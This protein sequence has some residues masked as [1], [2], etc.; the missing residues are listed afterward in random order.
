MKTNSVFV[1]TQKII[2]KVESHLLNYQGKSKYVLWFLK[3]LY[4]PIKFLK[5]G[6]NE[7]F[8]QLLL[9]YIISLG[10]FIII[11][12]SIDNTS[13]YFNYK[14]A[15]ISLPFS[16]AIG[17]VIFAMP[18]TYSFS[19]VKN[20]NI[21]FI[22]NYLKE[23]EIDDIATIEFIEQNFKAVYLSVAKR[24]KALKWLIGA[25]WAV[26]LYFINFVIKDQPTDLIDFLNSDFSV[27][28]GII[29]FFAILMI[30]SYIKA[31]DLLFKSIEFSLIEFKNQLSDKNEKIIN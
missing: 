3:H 24:I 4:F 23:L 7:I 22:V 14:W 15:I 21:E 28:S 9:I 25:S 31:S 17:L 16:L 30:A 26:L 8:R 18:S 2:S 5:I 13:I 10:S 11:V 29:V 6:L 12:Y 20:K 1:L 19:G 27:K